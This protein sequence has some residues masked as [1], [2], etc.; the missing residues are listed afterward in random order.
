MFFFK[1]TYLKERLMLIHQHMPILT[2]GNLIAVA[3]IYVSLEASRHPYLKAW[4]LTMSALTLIRAAVW[5]YYH[6]RPYNHT[7]IK[8]RSLVLLIFVSLSGFLWGVAGISFINISSSFESMI[9]MLVIAG[10]VSGALVSLASVLAVYILYATLLLLPV[11]LYLILQDDLTLITLGASIYIFLLA[12]IL[13]SFNVER[14]IINSIIL[15]DDNR[16][17]IAQLIEQKDIAEKSNLEKS[18]FLAAISHDLR[19]PLHA[20]GL[21]IDGLQPYVSESGKKVLGKVHDSSRAL[22]N[23][24][25]SLLDLSRLDAGV[26]KPYLEDFSLVPFLQKIVD[27]FASQAKMKGLY[28]EVNLCETGVQSDPVLLER[29]IRNLLANAIQYTDTGRILLENSIDGDLVTI[30]IQDEGRGI[31]EEELDNIFSSYHQLDNAERDRNK[32]V[33]LGLSIVRHICVLLS[34]PIQVDSR[35]G[36]GSSFSIK[37]PVV[38]QVQEK[39]KKPKKVKWDLQGQFIVVI[40]D[41]QDVRAATKQMLE[42]WGCDTITAKSCEEALEKLV[43]KSSRPTVLIADYRLVGENGIEVI[44]EIRR[45][46]GHNIAAMII[47]G[48]TTA[49]FS[50]EAKQHDLLVLHKPISPAELR[51]AIY[52]LISNSD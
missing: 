49:D 21:F 10:L 37:V 50:G 14:A 31:P 39:Q 48:D 35:V 22:K 47:T 1:L 17:L 51:T 23:L 19:Q 34:I 26:V 29:V 15:K 5:Y 33:G 4:A 9:L 6:I 28:L 30:R 11:G 20:M 18:K 36:H 41:E 45:H 2:A 8:V 27:E 25:N 40:D 32:G 44:A 3:I 13:M 43:T 7:N 42:S 52:Q 16:K 38:E 12:N 24:F 46:Y